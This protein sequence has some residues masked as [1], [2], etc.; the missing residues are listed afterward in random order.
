MR[1]TDAYDSA[2]MK[3]CIAVAKLHV[4]TVFVMF[5]VPFS[6]FTCILET[7]DVTIV[8]L[9][10]LMLITLYSR[11][12]IEFEQASVFKLNVLYRIIRSYL[13]NTLQ[14][15]ILNGII[16]L[17]DQRCYFDQKII[18]NEHHKYHYGNL[19]LW[20]SF[21]CSGIPIHYLLVFLWDQLVIVVFSS[22]QN[23]IDSHIAFIIGVLM[24]TLTVF[25]KKN[26]SCYEHLTN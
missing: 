19:Y 4:Q 14:I 1:C 9:L 6:H 24:E 20:W 5:Q 23:F 10:M 8:K 12:T 25:S 13:T 3:Y 21:A 26:L 22:Y 2:L 17:N 18:R 15:S 11:Q 16:Y 7:G